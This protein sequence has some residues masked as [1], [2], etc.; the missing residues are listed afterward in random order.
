MMKDRDLYILALYVVML[1]IVGY[2]IFDSILIGVIFGIG[3]GGIMGYIM[4]KKPPK[5]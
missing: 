5:K 1:F 4:S 2:L 3:S